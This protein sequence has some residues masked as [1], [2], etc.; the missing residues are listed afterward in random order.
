MPI[1][2]SSYRR[3]P[4]QSRVLHIHMPSLLLFLLLA[5]L[6]YTKAFAPPSRP[7]FFPSAI[8]TRST[9]STT[10]LLAA[11]T[12]TGTRTRPRRRDLKINSPV[13]EVPNDEEDDDDEGGGGGGGKK[14]VRVYPLGLGKYGDQT[15]VFL[16]RRK[17][18]GK[19]ER[20]RLETLPVPVFSSG[21]LE[22]LQAAFRGQEREKQKGRSSSSS[23]KFKPSV[24]WAGRHLATKDDGLFD[25]CPWQWVDNGGEGAA[26]AAAAVATA[27]AAAAEAKKEAYNAFVFGR[28]VDPAMFSSPYALMLH[29]VS[30]KLGA[31][32][33][34]LLIDEEDSPRGPGITFG[35][36][37][38]LQEEVSKEEVFISLY[39]D[40]LSSLYL[41][42]DIPLLPSPPPPPLLFDSS[43]HH[44]PPLLNDPPGASSSTASWTKLLASPSPSIA[45]SRCL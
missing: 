11:S 6:S 18:V 26:A 1:A 43:K 4:T 42:A 27:A 32:V 20:G 44:P 17:E 37:V 30:Q 39:S 5:N 36:V 8:T 28:D 41:D 40:L 12:L 38:M 33:L 15:A 7:C 34:E 9:T 29:V 45:P 19:E 16:A 3:G 13:P 10:R 22:M 21:D 23:S 25:N 24:L 35:P 14:W 31:V 2:S